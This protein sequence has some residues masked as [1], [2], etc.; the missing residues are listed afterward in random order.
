MISSV[1]GKSSSSDEDKLRFSDF[2]CRATSSAPSSIFIRFIG[3]GIISASALSIPVSF[4]P[5]VSS[6]LSISSTTFSFSPSISSSSNLITL[7][8]RRADQCSAL[9]LKAEHCDLLASWSMS[10]ICL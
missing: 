9:L 7:F 6:P 4:S 5:P 2:C 3:L 1:V 8:F 10:W